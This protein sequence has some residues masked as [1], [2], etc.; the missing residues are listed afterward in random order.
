MSTAADTSILLA[1]WGE[2]QQVTSVPNQERVVARRELRLE[3]QFT[4]GQ[5]TMAAR[6]GLLGDPV[7]KR[8]WPDDDEGTAAAKAYLETRLPGMEPARIVR[9]TSLTRT[10]VV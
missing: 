10:E 4:P 9:F 7:H 2:N 3:V 5:W 1:F 8:W 6:S